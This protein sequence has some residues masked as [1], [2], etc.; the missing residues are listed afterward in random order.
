[1]FPDFKN[2]FPKHSFW[3][4][5][6][7]FI[8]KPFNSDIFQITEKKQQTKNNN[9]LT[10]IWRDN[11]CFINCRCKKTPLKLLIFQSVFFSALQICNED[12]TFVKRR[13]HCR[14][15]GHVVCGNCS[16]QKAPLR[17]LRW[18][19]VRACDKCFEQLFDGKHYGNT[20]WW[21]SF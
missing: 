4:F 16:S 8:F 13:H 9:F 19:S 6:L 21:A 17:Y 11:W 10:N 7:H 15:C 5:N 14:A 1:M 2:C 12:F 18:E 20:G 3:Q